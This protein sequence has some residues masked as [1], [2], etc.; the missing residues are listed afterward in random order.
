[1]NILESLRP[2][3]IEFAQ[4]ARK[5]GGETDIVGDEQSSLAAE[6]EAAA[7]GVAIHGRF[8]LRRE[9]VVIALSWPGAW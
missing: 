7:L 6:L 3:A 1:M 5:A 9:G 4:A 2:E 8:Y